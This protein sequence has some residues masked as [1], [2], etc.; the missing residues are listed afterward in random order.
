VVEDL[1]EAP[2]LIFKMH[3]SLAKVIHL[4]QLLEVLALLVLELL[5]KKGFFGQGF[6][7][8][9]VQPLH[10]NGVILLHPLECGLQLGSICMA[11]LIAEY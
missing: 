10:C 7:E 4:L 3:G 11:E 6:L 1:I 9:H 8:L 2:P 5:F